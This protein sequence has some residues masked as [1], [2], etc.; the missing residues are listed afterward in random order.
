M[1]FDDSAEHRLL[2]QHLCRDICMLYHELAEYSFIMGD[3]D[4]T[5]LYT[6]PY[7]NCITNT[8]LD[9][10]SDAFIREGSLVMLLSMAWDCLDGS[11][12]YLIPNLSCAQASVASVTATDDQTTQLRTVVGTA[13]NTV[14]SGQT[15][16][17]K[18]REDSGWV[19]DTYVKGYFIQ[20]ARDFG[21][22]YYKE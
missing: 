2:A 8:G 5:N 15:E 14:S 18:L 6:L 4:Y 21:K 10:R 20:R 7:W 13:L 12:S 19:H 1:H 22:A 9:W 17:A 16:P 11:G 3:L